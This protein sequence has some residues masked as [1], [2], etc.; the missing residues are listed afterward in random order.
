[1]RA[2]LSLVYTST[3]VELREVVLKD[4]PEAMLTL[5]PK[6]T[7]PVL[8][9]P[10]G[11]VIDESLDI[12]RWAVAN[13]QKAHISERFIEDKEMASLIQLNDKEFKY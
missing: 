5:S 11:H 6:G 7:V 4:K 12:M 2:R 9:L 13:T 1:M 3:T 10:S 8:K